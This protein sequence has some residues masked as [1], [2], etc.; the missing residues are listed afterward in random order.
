MLETLREPNFIFEDKNL[1]SK[2][3][4]KYFLFV[5]TIYWDVYD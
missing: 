2:I 1:K 5:R 4:E 3:H